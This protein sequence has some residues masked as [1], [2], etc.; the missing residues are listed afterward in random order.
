MRVAKRLR[1]LR[2]CGLAGAGEWRQVTRR[3]VMPAFAPLF[4]RKAGRRS[5]NVPRV[6]QEQADE[7]PLAVAVRG[8]ISDG[9][10]RKGRQTEIEH[11]GRMPD[12]IV[13]P[14][15]GNREH[16]DGAAD[17]DQRRHE[18]VGP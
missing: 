14:D 18:Q 15:G 10:N 12:G 11:T 9:N 6:D 1:L 7:N 2:Q 8:Q 13:A 16:Q 5:I 3:F 4:G 17:Q